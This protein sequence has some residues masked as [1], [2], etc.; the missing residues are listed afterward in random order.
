LRAQL[1]EAL[2]GRGWIRTE[3]VRE[4]FLGTG[5]ELFVP[6]VA[7]LDGLESDYE[8]EQRSSRRR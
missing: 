1:V 2:H 7:Q 5:R 4:A 3:R 6:E 8:T